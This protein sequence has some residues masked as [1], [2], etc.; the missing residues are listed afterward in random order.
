[1]DNYAS[2]MKSGNTF[3]VYSFILRMTIGFKGRKSWV[4]SDTDIAKV[5][6][7]SHI[8]M[9]IHEYIKIDVSEVE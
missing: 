1:M 6:A 4:L 3:L 5:D 9:N 7:L 2:K 8:G